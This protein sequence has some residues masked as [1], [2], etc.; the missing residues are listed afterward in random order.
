MRSPGLEPAF[1]Q[2]ELAQI[3]DNADMG[4]GSLS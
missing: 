4:D 3:F 2:S 1:D